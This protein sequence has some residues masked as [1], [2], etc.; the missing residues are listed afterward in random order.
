MA[1]DALADGTVSVSVKVAPN[2]HTVSSVQLY[3]DKMQLAEARAEALEYSELLPAGEHQLWTRVFYDDNR[4]LDSEMT[5][6][7]VGSRD[8]SGWRLGIA[9]ETAATRNILQPTPDAFSFVGEGEYTIYRTIE[10][11]LTLT[12]RIAKCL[13]PNGEPVN[14][15]SW[16]GLSVREHA[17]K[18]GYQWGG[19]FGI[20]QT[21]GYGLRTTPDFS[22]LGAS[23]MS[24]PVL[25]EGLPW[26]RVVRQGAL[27][28]AWTSSDGRGWT[29]RATHYKPLSP[30]LGAGIVFRALPQDAQMYFR[31]T[32]TDLSL[33]TGVS[34]GFRLPD[35]EVAHGTR[36]ID[37]TGVVVAPSDPRVVV[38]RSA[39]RGLIRSDDGGQTWRQANGA[40]RGAANSVRSV[41]IHPTDPSVMLRA[42]GTGNAEGEFDGGLYRTEDAGATWVRLEFPGDFDGVGPSALCGEVIAFV[43]SNPDIIV[44]GCE[45]RG[46]FRSEDSG[47]TWLQIS[48]TRE[49]F[50]AVRMHP[51]DLTAARESCGHAVTCSDDMM[52]TLGR[53]EPV[54]KAE[55]E[56]SRDY[57][58][59]NSGKTFTVQSERSDLGYLSLAFPDYTAGGILYGTTQGIC[60]TFTDGRENYLT[61]DRVPVES[62]RPTTGVGVSRVRSQTWPRTYAQALSPAVPGR[63]SRLDYS[64]DSGWAW[65]VHSGAQPGGPIAIIAA[66]LDADA[67]GDDWWYLGF[68]GLYRSD[69]SL[70]TLVKMLE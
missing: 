37:L 61:L 46:L 40:L 27:W 42:A 8:P 52:L 36:E 23:R 16:V 11:D 22:D 55:T 14:P 38:V 17:E 60:S 34:E 66:D 59:H 5:P 67:S 3:L 21:A 25:P 43:P 54:L 63:V 6:V 53:G 26:L 65:Q 20:F 44:V 49:R 33:V 47:D 68:D 51:W 62:G 69:V 19:E 9:G 24:V 15:S 1:V 13:G 12:C 58:S 31:A 30:E 29:H 45:T 57:A 48:A 4:T 64:R 50:T 2:G 32:V 39:T 41:A 10:G 56:Q 28:T 7:S 35:A 70:G 18:G